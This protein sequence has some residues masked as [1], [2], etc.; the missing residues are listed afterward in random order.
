MRLSEM[1][2][3]EFA[4]AN[5]KAQFGDCGLAIYHATKKALAKGY[6]F[7]VTEGMV[8]AGGTILPHAWIEYQGRI[9]DPTK[10]QFGSAEVQYGPPGEYRDDYSP[11]EYISYF[12]DQYGDLL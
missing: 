6:D 11:Q 8:D 1:N 5:P 9:I 7:S 10:S 12:E 4:P 3:D 2:W